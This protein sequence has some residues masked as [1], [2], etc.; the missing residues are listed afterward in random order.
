ML[1]KLLTCAFWK[2]CAM[3]VCNACSF[4]SSCLECCE[5][6]FVTEEVELQSEDESI[7][8]DVDNCCIF[9]QKK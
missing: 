3:Y 1:S 7:D 8:L 6:H 4:D 2:Y 9:R 5:I